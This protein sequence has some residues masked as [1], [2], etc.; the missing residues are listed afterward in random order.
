M[1]DE[2]AEMMLS[3]KFKD[4]EEVI[5]AF[6]EAIRI[7]KG[8]IS[9]PT[10]DQIRAGVLEWVKMGMP[11]EIIIPDNLVEIFL[12]IKFGSPKQA[13]YFWVNTPPGVEHNLS[14]SELKYVMDYVNH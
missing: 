12:T 4:M 7:P 14:D 9:D 8:H 10:S 2:D 1:T 5:A 6:K 11:D 3:L 13:Y